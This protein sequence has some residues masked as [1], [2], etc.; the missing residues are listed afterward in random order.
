MG[1][2]VL[3]QNNDVYK[4]VQANNSFAQFE[5]A[6]EATNYLDHIHTRRDLILD[7]DDDK[8][9]KDILNHAKYNIVRDSRHKFDLLK[10]E[11]WGCFSADDFTKDI[12]SKH[13]SDNYYK[14]FLYIDKEQHIAA[15]S[16]LLDWG[17][18]PVPGKITNFY[19]PDKIEMK[20]G[21]KIITAKLYVQLKEPSNDKHKCLF[22]IAERTYLGYD[23]D[24]ENLTPPSLLGKHY[25]H[26]S[27]TQGNK[28]IYTDC[29]FKDNYNYDDFFE[30][31]DPSDEDAIIEIWESKCRQKAVKELG[32]RLVEDFGDEAL[33]HIEIYEDYGED[34]F[35]FDNEYIAAALC[36]DKRW[37]IGW[38]L[39]NKDKL[40]YI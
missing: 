38:C 4:V 35:D 14:F 34:G 12:A 29:Y 10:P 27:K 36:F 13:I 11:Y 37:L 21:G 20:Y 19:Y 15:L 40:E 6:A 26:L 33:A 24:Q 31:T 7:F 28:A 3:K 17:A 2:S 32:R 25:G 30:G 5:S 23:A 8:T 16:K 22:K 9:A 39:N 18:A 1:Y